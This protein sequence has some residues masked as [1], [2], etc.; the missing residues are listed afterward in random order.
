MTGAE[1]KVAFEAGVAG[2]SLL[3]QLASFLKEAEDK[4]TPVKDLSE[5]IAHLPGHAYS[6]SKDI[7]RHCEEI[8]QTF[9]AEK[10]D[11][12]KTI[13]QLEKNH[14]IWGTN[15]YDLVRD[16]VEHMSA[17]SNIIGHNIDGFIAVAR[18]RDQI[19][20]VADGF[21][22]AKER[23]D[24]I[25]TIVNRDTPVRKILDDMASWARQ[26]RDEIQKYI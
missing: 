4:G 16:F 20:L 5:V 22:N 21:G 2:L 10:I 26:L 3:A 23:K 11:I 13:A 7:I 24:A 1:L 17:L 19:G 9:I 12:D 15:K 6:I 25:D 8:K 18:C 14:W